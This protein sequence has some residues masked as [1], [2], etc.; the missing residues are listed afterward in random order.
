VE[1]AVVHL[2]PGADDYLP[3]DRRS[4]ISRTLSVFQLVVAAL[5][6]SVWL[7]GSRNPYT[8]AGYVGYLTK[9]AV[10]GKTGFYGVLRCKSSAATT[11]GRSSSPSR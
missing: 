3:P 6:I 5:S 1:P 8:P 2:M 7:I 9:G 4:L 10:F 11:S